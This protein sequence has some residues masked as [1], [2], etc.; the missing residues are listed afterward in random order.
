M[1]VARAG[2]SVDET[3]RNMLQALQ[4][5]LE[6]DPARFESWLVGHTVELGKAGLDPRVLREQARVQGPATRELGQK[7]LAAWIDKV[8]A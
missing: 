7:V 1:A 5:H 4:F 6:T 2:D 8:D 3:R